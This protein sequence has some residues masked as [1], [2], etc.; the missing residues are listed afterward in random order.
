M[1]TTLSLDDDVA[2][3]LSRMQATT[4]SS[5]KEVVNRGLREGLTRMAAPPSPR[6]RFRTASVSLG[7]CLLPN[8]D[9]IGEVLAVIEGDQYK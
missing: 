9:N 4:G 3:L 2:V 8:L 7:R 6:K 5:M 1:R